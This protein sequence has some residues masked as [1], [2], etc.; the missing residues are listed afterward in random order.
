[1]DTV[2]TV[3][4]DAFSIEEMPAATPALRQWC[5]AV[6]M[7]VPSESFPAGNAD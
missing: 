7:E 6:D 2:T 5:A 3:A 4:R 1:V